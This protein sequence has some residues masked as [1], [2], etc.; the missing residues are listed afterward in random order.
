GW[1]M[2]AECYFAE[3]NYDD[4]EKAITKFIPYPKENAHQ[5]KRSQLLL[6]SCVFAKKALA[7]PV[8]F[9]PINLGPGINTDRDE[10]Y[11]CITA[12]EQT[13]L[14]TRL[15]KDERAQ[16]GK[17]EDFYISKK[18]NG[19]WQQAEPVREINTPKNEGA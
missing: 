18:V 16:T 11:P 8:P 9:N 15:V 14:F 6:S 12:D 5:E 1:M 4:A 7:N 17:Q 2:L 3:A 19:E 13:L 10:Y